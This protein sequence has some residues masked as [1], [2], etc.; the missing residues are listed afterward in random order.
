MFDICSGVQSKIG[1]LL[2]NVAV[3]ATK[4]PV[5]CLNYLGQVCRVWGRSAGQHFMTRGV[6]RT[7]TPRLSLQDTAAYYP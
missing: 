5:L 6:N 7:G 1:L 2:C 4:V 3:A